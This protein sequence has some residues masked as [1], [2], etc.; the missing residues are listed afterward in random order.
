MPVETI[1]ASILKEI[2]TFRNFPVTVDFPC[3][4]K[5][6]KLV[7]SIQTME[8]SSET[9][10]YSVAEA[11]NENKEFQLKEYWC[12]AGNGQGDRW[13]LNME[14][15][16]FFYD[17]DADETLIP[18]NITFEQWLQMAYL[19]SDLDTCLEDYDEIS[20]SVRKAFYKAL[21]TIQEGLAEKY[22]FMV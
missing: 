1:E 7:A 11:V 2:K 9:F 13:F 15:A 19:I 14:G 5:Y 8:I 4:E 6:K 17:H 18:M 21:N 12:F 22:P 3:P 20:E 10:L 16:V